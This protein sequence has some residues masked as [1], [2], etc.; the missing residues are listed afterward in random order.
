MTWKRVVVGVDGSP[1]SS[2]ALRFAADEAREHD[3]ELYVVTSYTIPAPPV[4]TAY[5]AAPWRDEREWLADAEG[6]LRS[7][8]ADTLGDHPGLQVIGQAIEGSAAKVLIDASARADLLVV[9]TRGHGG[10]AG[11]LLG[12]VSQHLT[13]HA[14]CAVT[15]VR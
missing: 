11:M 4:A 3:A 15:V 12:S 1:S 8:V 7:T 9:G 10:F 6:T 13:A 5:G 2:R 14:A